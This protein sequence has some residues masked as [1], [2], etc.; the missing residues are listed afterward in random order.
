MIYK[1]KTQYL[2]FLF[3]AL[4]HINIYF[5]MENTHFSYF[6]FQKIT[7]CSKNHRQQSRKSRYNQRPKFVIWVRIFKYIL[8]N[9]YHF[10]YKTKE[11]LLYIIFDTIFNKK[12]SFFWKKALSSERG[13]LVQCEGTE[14]GGGL[15]G[16]LKNMMIFSPLLFASHTTAFKYNSLIQERSLLNLYQPFPTNNRLFSS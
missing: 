15:Q 13:V 6:L 2:I 8:K 7:F 12:I 11:Y 9:I 4:H 16:Y 10:I 14:W 3:P 5:S 1:H